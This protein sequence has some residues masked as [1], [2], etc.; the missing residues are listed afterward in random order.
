M[1]RFHLLGK[2][3]STKCALC[4]CNIPGTFPCTWLTNSNFQIFNRPDL[5]CTGVGMSDELYLWQCSLESRRWLWQTNVRPNNWMNQEQLFSID[6]KRE[7]SFAIVYTC[8]MFQKKFQT[9]ENYSHNCSCTSLIQE[10]TEMYRKIYR[11]FSILRYFW[12]REKQIFISQKVVQRKLIKSN[13]QFLILI[14]FL[15]NLFF[16]QNMSFKRIS[17]ASSLSDW[18]NFPNSELI[19]LSFF[20]QIRL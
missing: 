16:R 2:P 14:W 18:P 15:C 3:M 19:R 13:Y 7:Q 20:Y 5:H 9:V 8:L 10:S 4:R 11:Y 6:C 17:M 1:T 12:E